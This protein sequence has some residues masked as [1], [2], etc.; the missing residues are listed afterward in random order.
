MGATNAP[1][2]DAETHRDT[3]APP[4]I[5]DAMQLQIENAKKCHI[6][7]FEKLLKGQYLSEGIWPI[8][9]RK[10]FPTAGDISVNGKLVFF[11]SSQC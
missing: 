4:D 11:W 5:L 7:G 2:E 3:S 9:G 8:A 10:V 6:R 1:S